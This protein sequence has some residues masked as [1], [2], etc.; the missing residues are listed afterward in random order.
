MNA[1]INLN[2]NWRLFL[3]KARE[4][5]DGF[6]FPEKGVAAQVPGT[7]HTDLLAAGLIPD[8]FFGMNEK[9]LQWI[10]RND[11]RYEN[12]FD[13]PE[14][15]QNRASWWLVFE[16]LDTVTEI[17]LNG[18]LLGSTQ[19]MFRSY[20]FKIGDR[21][22]AKENHLR[23]VFRS[24]LQWIA[25][26][27]RPIRQMPSVRHPDRVFMRKSQYAFGW[28]WGPQFPTSGIWRPVYVLQQKAGIA[29]SYFETT[30]LEQDRA[31][32][33]LGCTLWGDVPKEA[34]VS[35]E[36]QHQGACFRG[37]MTL[38]GN[39]AQTEIEIS[40]PALWW[41]NGEGKP[42]LHKLAI[43]LKDSEGQLWDEQIR[44]VGIR[45]VELVTEENGKATFY[46][47]INDRKI[48]LKGANWI[49]ADSF[50]PRVSPDKY[51]YLLRKAQ[52][53]NMN[54]LRV[55]GGGIY[56]NE[57]FYELCDQLGLMVWQ[58][59]MFACA[60][61]PQDEAFAAEV[62][63]ELTE[64]VGRLQTHPS[65]I[66]WCGNNENEWIWHRDM[67]TPSKE[68]PGYELFH[69]KFPGWLK[70]LDA[71]R[72]YWP[73]TPWGDE[74]D[75]NDSN[76][77]N[78]HA[79]E[80]WSWWQDYS[81]VKKDR[82]LFVTEF[83]FQAPAHVQT[84]RESLPEQA[85]AVQSPAF[86]WHNKQEEGPERLF[87]FLSAHLPVRIEPSDFIYLTQLNQAFALQM[88]LEHWRTNGITSGAII[89]Q[90]N[91]CW[92]V[93]SWAL[94]DSRLR[95]KLAY[96]QVRR[97]FA[98]LLITAQNEDTYV[99]IHVRNDSRHSFQGFFNLVD[100][101]MDKAM[102]QVLVENDV[103]LESG[104]ELILKKEKKDLAGS[105]QVAT[106]YDSNR[107]IVARHVINLEPWKYLRLPAEKDK[108]EL[109]KIEQNV[110]QLVS[111]VPLFF[112]ELR[113]AFARF[114]DQGFIVLPG[115]RKLVYVENEN[116]AVDP[117]DIEIICLNR[118][119]S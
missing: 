21:L 102:V 71:S 58:D 56:E 20:R 8:P 51:T 109:K 41:P 95:A 112:V 34:Q 103:W 111:Q 106:L 45:T 107:L 10:A 115:E 35:F 24:P 13:L 78:R 73:T 105:I 26:K 94:I 87:R 69:E 54:V 42:I 83:G 101:R 17:W 104:Q 25:E 88:C 97:S 5:P 29:H 1:K 52:E 68:M 50:L 100:V 77:G 49:P 74:A 98:P 30:R 32:V 67:G 48:F 116:Q 99:K 33:R 72:P 117:G 9:D 92:P 113:H 11:W 89:W 47:K 4:I 70:D 65:I 3:E 86:E 80:I 6:L 40:K 12:Y 15:S 7:V 81:T 91:D 22:Q 31:H 44:R 37:L 2:D 23:I 63:A 60:A 53:A 28:D 84:M 16:G 90:I 93:S 110:L 18:Q 62:K 43:R 64:N 114:S 57:I 119:L 96:Y 82:S 39:R 118:Y 27:R 59:F 14:F 75:P 36:L 19:N 38:H 79:W 76:S 85:F 66:I 55:W 108:I 46:F 61:Y